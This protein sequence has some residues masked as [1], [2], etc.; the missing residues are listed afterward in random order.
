MEE[1]NN[2][3]NKKTQSI[4]NVS[5]IIYK[6][7]S[8]KYENIST[9]GITQNNI[10]LIINKFQ[11]K[12]KT[13]NITKNQIKD[14]INL[15]E[16]KINS[17]NKPISESNITN[18]LNNMEVNNFIKKDFLN[19]IDSQ[20]NNKLM[21]NLKFLN[22]T[23][24]KTKKDNKEE[25]NSNIETQY[26]P[27]RE[28]FP[29][30]QRE[31]LTE[32]MIPETIDKEFFIVIDSKDR[33]FNLYSKPN[34]YKIDFSP[35]DTKSSGYISKGFNNVKS[36]ELIE[37]VILDTTSIVNSSNNGSSFPYLILE[38]SELG[39]NFEGTNKELTNAFSLLK[40][41]NSQNGYFYYDLIGI[42][43]SNTIIKTFNPNKN[44]SSLTINFKL[45]DGTPFNFGDDSDSNTSTVNKLVFRIITS[46]KNLAS[47]F[48]DQTTF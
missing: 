8:K 3:K 14:V 24:N 47:Q 19:K 25:E 39:G 4:E 41:Y 11:Q 33:D 15:L 30:K 7:L 9:L 35:S 28:N 29:L 45:P 10:K 31:K 34:N 43:S 23:N 27:Y 48:L 5:N 26:K 13:Q 37:C 21:N 6:S 36:I 32:M 12:N 22:D 1:I 18:N 16:K 44:L 20:D 38:I 46:Q 40:N 17:N 2:Q 42:N